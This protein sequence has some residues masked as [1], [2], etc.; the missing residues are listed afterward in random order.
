MR[1]IIFTFILL[2]CLTL[3]VNAQTNE[4]K[5][6]EQYA[7]LVKK[8]Y[9]QQ[10]KIYKVI[11]LYKDFSQKVYKQR[12]Q[13]KDALGHTSYEDAFKIFQGDKNKIAQELQQAASIWRL[14]LPDETRRLQMEDWVDD[15]M[16]TDYL[17]ELELKMKL[18]ENSRKIGNLL[19]DA[20]QKEVDKLLAMPDTNWEDNIS[21]LDYEQRAVESLKKQF[22]PN[23]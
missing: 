2:F 3:S 18:V 17:G 11:G 16:R 21:N 10:L 8:R 12:K 23:Q 20:D 5:I 14:L 19:N 6:N 15:Q 1:T 4:Q 9:D 7:K 22:K 13:L